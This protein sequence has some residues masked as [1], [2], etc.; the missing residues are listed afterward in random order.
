MNLDEQVWIKS[1]VNWDLYFD[2]IEGTGTIKLI[3]NGKKTLK[4]GEIQSQI[5]DNNVMFTGTDGKGSHARIIIENDEARKA[6]FEL[7]DEELTSVNAL[8]K[9][10]IKEINELKTQKAFEKAI[11]DGVVSDAEKRLF[12]DTAFELGLTDVKRIKFVED[13]TGMKVKQDIE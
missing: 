3:P 12:V 4:F 1:T 13:H 5:Y 9:E 7:L 6:A 11:E 8:D 10:K 2:R